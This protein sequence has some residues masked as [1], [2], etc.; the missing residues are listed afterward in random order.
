MFGE[1]L[2]VLKLKGK[3]EDTRHVFTKFGPLEYVNVIP[4]VLFGVLYIALC[5]L[6]WFGRFRSLLS[7]IY[8]SERILV[9]Y[10]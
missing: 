10:K 8:T 4:N 9:D 2:P 6:S 1:G 3:S 5:T 7:F